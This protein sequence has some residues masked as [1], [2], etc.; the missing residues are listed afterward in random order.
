MEHKIDK[1]TKS[2]TYIKQIKLNQIKKKIYLFEKRKDTYTMEER[3]RSSIVIY[4]GA[5]KHASAKPPHT[6]QP[7]KASICKIG[8][9]YTTTFN[10]NLN[11]NDDD[12]VDMLNLRKAIPSKYVSYKD[13][14]SISSG[15]STSTSVSFFNSRY[16]FILLKF[17]F[18]KIC[19]G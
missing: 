12:D 10:I 13:C 16:K 9:Q 2:T 4:Q 1:L 11:S 18:M 7:V 15:S 19:P 6:K 8:Q 17:L 14:G 3:Y 5:N